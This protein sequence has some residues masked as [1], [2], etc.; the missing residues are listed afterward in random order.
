MTWTPEG[1]VAEQR[2]V[3][4]AV[5]PENVRK[6]TAADVGQTEAQVEPGPE[7]TQSWAVALLRALWLTASK[8]TN[9]KI[10]ELLWGL[11]TARSA[12]RPTKSVDD[13]LEGQQRHPSRPPALLARHTGAAP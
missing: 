4:R 1:V 6:R 12:C 7:S 2:A 3:S 11:L 13:G 8:D 10:R 5:S 9:K